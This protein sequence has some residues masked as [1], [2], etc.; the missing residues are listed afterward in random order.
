M[1]KT[2]LITGLCAAAASL[3][4]SALAQ[5]APSGHDS[6]HAAPARPGAEEWVAAEI[7][8][9]DLA[10][11]KLTLK[12]AEIKH[13]DM[14]G[15]TMVFDLKEGAATTELLAALKPGDKLSVQILSTNGRLT[16]S[17]LRR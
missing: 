7:R 11:R 2:R 15:M 12:H 14:P 3:P 10:G 17:A 9:V 13:L 5:T 8:R 1:M 4:L 6:H 16:V